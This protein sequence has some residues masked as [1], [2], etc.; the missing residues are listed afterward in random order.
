MKT[1]ISLGLLALVIVGCNAQEVNYKAKWTSPVL[2]TLNGPGKNVVASEHTHTL[3]GND[4]TLVIKC[5]TS[6]TSRCHYRVWHVVSKTKDSAAD[7]ATININLNETFFQLVVDESKTIKPA[8]E[9]S[10]FCHAS[11]KLPD[12]AACFRVKI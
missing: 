1:A 12:A 7:S 3:L 9:G 5:K 2:T 10:S 4:S 11:D 8:L 6:D